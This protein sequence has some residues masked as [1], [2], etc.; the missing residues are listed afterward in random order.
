LSLLAISCVSVYDADA[1]A[2]LWGELSYRFGVKLGVRHCPLCEV[3]HC[4]KAVP[5]AARIKACGG[6]PAALIA[7]LGAGG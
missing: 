7:A 1:D 2:T 6:S 4:L 3:T 5:S